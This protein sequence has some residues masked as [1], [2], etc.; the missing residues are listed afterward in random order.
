MEVF[1]VVISK[2]MNQLPNIFS[3]FQ[4]AQT[5][6]YGFVSFDFVSFGFVSFDLISFRFYFVPHLYK[7]YREETTIKKCIDNRNFKYTLEIAH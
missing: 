2:W 3:L 5:K 7:I 4:S 6:H 1:I